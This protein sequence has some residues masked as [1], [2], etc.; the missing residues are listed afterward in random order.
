MSQPQLFNESRRFADNE[1][2]N[3]PPRSRRRY[4]QVYDPSHEIIESGTDVVIRRTGAVLAPRIEG[5]NGLRKL[6]PTRLEE[7]RVLLLQRTVNI[8][9]A[10]CGSVQH[11]MIQP[12]AVTIDTFYEIGGL[13][14]FLKHHPGM[15]YLDPNQWM[16]YI[17]AFKSIVNASDQTLSTNFDNFYKTF[18]DPEI[19]QDRNII[20]LEQNHAETPHA[21]EWNI[22]I[23]SFNNFDHHC[24]DLL[25]K[26]IPPSIMPI[27]EADINSGCYNNP[28]RLY[29]KYCFE[30]LKDALN[31][32]YLCWSCMKSWAAKDQF[33]R[34]LKKKH[35]TEI[36]LVQ[37]LDSAESHRVNREEVLVDSNVELNNIVR[38]QRQEINQAQT[39]FAANHTNHNADRATIAE[40]REQVLELRG[41]LELARLLVEHNYDGRLQND[42]F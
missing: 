8:L 23:Q 18:D 36:D 10:E 1:G 20:A 25:N 7:C 22:I 37:Q 27:N 9:F 19:L 31:G 17:E 38:S 4:N 29:I 33:K 2:D 21:T 30:S 42:L 40:L 35:R 24:L 13:K 14:E 39:N 41:E 26:L 34:H 16:P 6:T 3:P 11:N 5:Y 28:Q 15:P 12:D 32:P